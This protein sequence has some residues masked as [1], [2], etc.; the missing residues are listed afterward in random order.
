[1]E[2]N[3][4]MEKM[5]KLYDCFSDIIFDE[6]ARKE[7]G[8]TPERHQ[9]GKEKMKL[10]FEQALLERQLHE[11]TDNSY[12][13]IGKIM[14]DFIRRENELYKETY[15]KCKK[16]LDD[17]NK[18]YKEDVEQVIKEN[19]ENAEKGNTELLK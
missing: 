14:V 16:W 7:M 12:I 11:V 10:M 5:E 3:E 2:N 17:N 9:I 1:M 19:K 4:K 18:P 15:E 13:E 6:G 8:I